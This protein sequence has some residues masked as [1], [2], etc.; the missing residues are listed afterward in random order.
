M[1]L[2]LMLLLT[3]I[4]RSI[5]HRPVFQNI[6]VWPKRK[7]RIKKELLSGE[8]SRSRLC[9]ELLKRSGSAQPPSFSFHAFYS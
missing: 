1:L 6:P 9:P 2:R 8:T 3:R 5:L 4:L 7:V